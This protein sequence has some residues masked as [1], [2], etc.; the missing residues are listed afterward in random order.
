MD[1]F[2]IALL[3]KYVIETITNAED[4]G[5]GKSAYDIAL[6]NGFS[7]TEQEWLESLKGETPQIG[8]NGHWIIAGVDTG[9]T[10]VPDL[11]S[12]YDKENLKALT[13]EEIF[14]IINEIRNA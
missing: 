11:D 4:L 6:E 9:L 5:I 1:L 12:F 10:A 2:T 13:A 7:G 3:K 8:E 14:S